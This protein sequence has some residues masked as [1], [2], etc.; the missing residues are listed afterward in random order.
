MKINIAKSKGRLIILPFY[1]IEN[2]FLDPK[3]IECVARKILRTSAPT[4]QQIEDK[5]IQLA[6]QQL[7]HAVSLYVKSEIYFLAGNF[8]VS[9]KITIDASTTIANMKAAM[10]DKRNE[11]LTNYGNKFSDVVIEQR[12]NS[13]KQV[14]EDSIKG[15]WTP[16]AR[17]FFIGKRMLRELQAW[18]FRNNDILLWEHIV[19]SEDAECVATCQEL[20]GILNA[21]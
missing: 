16:Q 13:W 15:G 6:K 1:H 8:D 9:P 11:L 2:A 14:L 4:A 20:R 7:N 18:L 3:A 10:I 5:M 12:L 21:I 19:N 17:E